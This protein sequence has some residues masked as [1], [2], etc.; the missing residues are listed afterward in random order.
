MKKPTLWYSHAL[1]LWLRVQPHPTGE[2]CILPNGQQCAFLFRGVLVC[3]AAFRKTGVELA[4]AERKVV[5][6]RNL[7][8]VE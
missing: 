3:P 4:C 5:F 7:K 2:T 1:G 6:T 8:T